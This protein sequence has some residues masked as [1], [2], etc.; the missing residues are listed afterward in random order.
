MADKRRTRSLSKGYVDLIVEL[1]N[2]PDTV[3]DVVI[4]GSGYG[5]SVAAQQLAGL[6]HPDGKPLRIAVLERGSEYLPGMFPSAFADLPKHV[7]FATQ[8]TGKVTGELEGLY[9]V[10]LGDDVNALVANGLGGGSLINAGVLIEPDQDAFQSNDYLRGVQKALISGNW[11]QKAKKLLLNGPLQQANKNTIKRHKDY[12][13][14]PQGIFPLKFNRLKELSIGA[15]KLDS[16]VEFEAA[17]ISVAMRDVDANEQS[18]GMKACNACGDCMTGCNVGAKASLNTNLLAQAARD[19]VD[20]YTGASVLTLKRT[21]EHSSQI[22]DIAGTQNLWELEVVHTSLAL[23]KREP[24]KNNN[25]ASNY[26]DIRIPVAVKARHVILAAGTF[27][28]TEILLRSRSEKLGFSNKLGERFSCNGDNIAAIHGLHKEAHCTDDEFKAI[29]KRNV[30]PTITGTIKVPAKKDE[31]GY[32]IQEFAVPA[33]LKRLFDELVTTTKVVND[34]PTNDTSTH[35]YENTAKPDTHDPCAVNPDAMNRTLLLGFI[36]HDD[37]KGVMRLPLHVESKGVRNDQEG[38]L[39]IVWPEAR[40]GHQINKAFERLKGYSKKA[41]P[42]ASVISN[43]MW[44]FLPDSIAMIVKPPRGPVLTVHP[45]GGCAIGETKDD[46]V[47]DQFGVVF[48]AGYHPH[49]SWEKTLLVLD[50]SIIPGS[51]GANP[52]LT[53][54]AIALRAVNNFL[55]NSVTSGVYKKGALTQAKLTNNHIFSEAKPVQN[56]SPQSTEVSVT[57]RLAGTVTLFNEKNFHEDYI[58][59][60]TLKYKPT[61][62]NKLMNKWGTR[63]QMLVAGSYLRLFRWSEWDTGKQLRVADDALLEANAIYKAVVTGHLD[64]FGR[65]KKSNWIWFKTFW[66]GLQNRGWRDIY[67]AVFGPNRNWKWADAINGKFYKTLVVLRNL[68][69]R[70]SEVRTFDYVVSVGSNQSKMIDVRSNYFHKV[71]A[72]QQIKGIKRLTYNR[73]AN[74][75]QQMLVMKLCQFP[76]M[77][78]NKNAELKVDTRFLANQGIPLAEISKQD[79]QVNALLDMASFGLFMARVIFNN[80][81]LSFRSPDEIRHKRVPNRLPTRMNGL[82][83]PEITELLVSKFDPIYKKPAASIRLTRYKGNNPNNKPVALIHGYSANGTTFAHPSLKPSI[84]EYLWKNGTFAGSDALGDRDIWVIDLRSSS[85]MPT[86]NIAWSY[87]EIALVDIPAALLHI[88]TITGHK[89]DVVAHCV[90]AAMLSMAILT[91][92]E[93]VTTDK[94]QLG[95]ATYIQDE[96]LGILSAFNG[97]GRFIEGKPTTEPHPTINAIVMS[98]KGP[99]IRYTEENIFRAYVMKF[100][101]RWIVPEGYAFR[102]SET[103]TATEKLIDRLLSTLPYPDAEY[104]IEN[105][106][107]PC[108]RTE[109]VTSRHRMDAL[110]A[111]AFNAENMTKETLDCIDDFFGPLNME[112]VM[113]TIHFVRFNCITNQRGR[114]EFVSLQNL[115]NRWYGI[116]TFSIHGE[117]NGMVDATTRDLIRVNFDAA[118]IEYTNKLYPNFGH[119]DLFIG[120][121]CHEVF[122]DIKEFLDNPTIFIANRPSPTPI[123]IAPVKTWHIEVPWIGPRLHIGSNDN[124]HVYAMSSTKYGKSKMVLVPVDFRFVLINGYTRNPNK[125][126][127]SLSVNTQLT[128]QDWHSMEIANVGGNN[129]GQSWLVLMAYESD[130][131]FIDPSNADV[132]NFVIAPAMQATATVINQNSLEFAIDDWFLNQTSNLDNCLISSLDIGHWQRVGFNSFNFALASCQFPP[133]IVDR[134]VSEKSMQALAQAVDKKDENKNDKGEKEYIDFVIF[135]GDQIYADATAGLMDPTRRDERLDLPYDVALRSAPMRE[136]MRKVPVHMLLDDHEI[137]DNWEL[138][139]SIPIQSLDRK[140]FK[141]MNPFLINGLEAYWKYQRLEPVVVADP[142][143]LKSDREYIYDQ[144]VSYQFDHGNAK[145]YMLDTRSQRQFRVV[146]YPDLAMMFSNIQLKA[147]CKWLLENKDA[148]KFV[149]TPSILLPRR[150][151]ALNNDLDY[152]NRSDSWAGY[153]GVMEE[154]ISFIAENQVKHTVFLSGDEHL[155]CHATSTISNRGLTAKI[156]SIHASGLYAPFPFAN[157]K[158]EDFI[159]GRDV[160]QSGNNICETDSFFAP[161]ETRFAKIKVGIDSNAKPT[162]SVEY[163]GASGAIFNTFELL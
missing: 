154:I 30:G 132:A 65:E 116:P 122:S 7:R 24:T 37:A 14:N 95:V 163:H 33:P 138:T 27:G 59:E 149:V 78:F 107:W 130:Q 82:P 98:Q 110:Y 106:K 146:D 75:W 40:D 76:L 127:S 125:P 13:P 11:Y 56:L 3:F 152:P 12:S 97:D 10:R 153:P 44:R 134:E 155:S 90:G 139:S 63:R 120:R 159:A 145:F 162:V 140:Q 51:L 28:S 1:R 133:G 109:W 70:G 53:I 31:L 102:Q 119:Q 77:H 142:N 26:A 114:G 29:A 99:L 92:A 101:Q 128:S 104:D 118:N 17:E 144:N 42:E 136:I 58:L 15:K 80:H 43:P 129:A 88:K 105:P 71:L 137:A 150:L 115:K 50:G 22:Y 54:S 79:N 6:T 49:D 25:R 52:S 148:L 57:E 72:T 117:E 131:I 161:L 8:S 20:I 16:V 103:P 91:R 113:Q 141:K 60:L 34:L 156:V 38:V 100:L 81:I 36:G 64:F 67:D 19:K 18:I 68:I 121:A 94:V 74:P 62:L 108:A 83:E 66:A 41:F 143:V 35:G 84:A 124:L 61:E 160:F 87:E 46:G 55:D 157:A 45:L 5:G 112:T 126:N 21:I 123:G 151:D 23:R 47:V 111:R 147:L 93:D 85:G 32:L 158:Q 86:A 9:D 96:Q 4:V 2:K 135:A 69:S 48:N 39:Q 73:R 89:V